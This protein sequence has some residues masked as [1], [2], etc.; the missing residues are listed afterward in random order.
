MA[1]AF[2]RGERPIQPYH[3]ANTYLATPLSTAQLAAS[4]QPRFL[5][6]PY[7]QNTQ[8]S[9]TQVE[10]ASPQTLQQA[11]NASPNVISGTTGGFG[12]TYLPW[13]D[14][15]S[16]P[17]IPLNPALDTEYSPTLVDSQLH[18]GFLG[19]YEA[20]I[21]YQYTARAFPFDRGPM[22]E[23]AVV[24][25]SLGRV[26]LHHPVEHLSNDTLF[27]PGQSSVPDPCAVAHSH[28]VEAP[29]YFENGTRPT[30]NVV[31]GMS[32]SDLASS[33]SSS[34]AYCEP[35]RAPILP[36][37]AVEDRENIPD[38]QMPASLLEI[39]LVEAHYEPNDTLESDGIG[40]SQKPDRSHAKSKNKEDL[41]TKRRSAVTRGKSSINHTEKGTRSA[42]KKASAQDAAN[43]TFARAGPPPEEAFCSAFSATACPP[44]SDDPPR[45]RLIEDER[46]QLMKER[47]Q[48]LVE[49]NIGRLTIAQ[50]EATYRFRQQL[51]LSIEDDLDLNILNEGSMR[52]TKRTVAFYVQ[53]VLCCSEDNLLT[54]EEVCDVMRGIWCFKQ[55]SAAGDNVWRRTVRCTLS[56][57]KEFGCL[58]LRKPRTNKEINLHFLDFSAGEGRRKARERKSKSLRGEETHKN[59]K[60]SAFAGRPVP[61]KLKSR[62]EPPYLSF[63][64]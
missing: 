36:P 40:G 1:P 10:Y 8:H 63:N 46:L 48:Q 27:E 25:A 39:K 21:P 15:S 59:S 22:I 57:N 41:P 19:P 52:E 42:V 44:L 45:W 5:N 53:M 29:N 64:Q 51:G 14:H 28:Q 4:S 61:S 6:F 35:P 20:N 17:L 3:A 47:R 7:I 11:H 32:P 12:V 13:D 37:R 23:P 26:G 60:D 54:V 56:E 58:K 18:H 49:E 43:A 24:E 50:L 55:R 33:S 62:F 34:Q 16:G 30:N 31:H 2:S 9:P 38:I